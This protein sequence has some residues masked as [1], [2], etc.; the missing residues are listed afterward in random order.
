MC[1]HAVYT[2]LHSSDRQAQWIEK[3]GVPPTPS[4]RA[5]TSTNKC[6]TCNSMVLIT[7]AFLIWCQAIRHSYNGDSL[8]GSNT[9]HTCTCHHYQTELNNPSLP[10]MDTKNIFP[11]V[12]MAGHQ[13][14]RFSNLPWHVPIKTTPP[15]LKLSHTMEHCR[16]GLG[17]S[18]P[19]TCTTF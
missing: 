1:T 15:F 9:M 18:T 16:G 2:H 19:I 3:Q 13:L 5:T 6:S 11:W 10:H 7:T 12:K 8:L 4:P 14:H 17:S